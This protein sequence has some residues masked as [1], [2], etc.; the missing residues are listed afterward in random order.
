MRRLVSTEA[1]C[2]QTLPPMDVTERYGV[3]GVP[4]L[5][6]D[7]EALY[8]APSNI[9][10]IIFSPGDGVVVF[11]QKTQQV[12]PSA[13]D[14]INVRRLIITTERASKQF[15][16]YKLFEMNNRYTRRDV[17]AALDQYWRSVQARNGVYAYQVVCDESNNTAQVIDN[18]QLNVDVYMQPQKSAEFIQLQSTTTMTWGSRS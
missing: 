3:P 1:S 14:R 4:G 10:P 9:N 13:L 8:E 15:L 12:K 2:A 6:G 16:K 7:I 17:F 11:D 5:I 18:N